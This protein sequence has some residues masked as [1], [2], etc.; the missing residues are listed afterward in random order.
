MSLESYLA[1]SG[2]PMDDVGVQFAFELFVRVELPA[3]VELV[4]QVAEHLLGGGV[5]QAVALA[6]HGLADAEAFELAPPLLVLVLPS[7]VRVQ[8]RL[9]AGGQ[10]LREHGEQALLPPEV[11]TAAHVPGDDLLAGHVV[12]GSEVRLGAG[13]LEF[14][15][16]GAELGERTGR[17]E[18]A[19][20]Q[21]MHVIARLAPV[22]VVPPPR[23]PGADG[24]S[25]SH[26][27]HDPGQALDRHLPSE[28][29]DQAHAYLS[30]AASVRRASPDLADQWL[31]IGPRHTLRMR[32]LIEVRGSGQSRYPQE[33]VE[34]VS[35]PCEQSDDGASLAPRDLDASRV[36]EFFQVRDL[37]LQIGD[38]FGEL[39]LARRFGLRFGFQASGPALGSRPERLRTSGPVLAA[40]VFQGCDARDPVHG[41][42]LRLGQTVLDVVAR[43]RDLRLPH[44]YRI[45][46]NAFIPVLIFRMNHIHRW[47]MKTRSLGHRYP[48]YPYLAYVWQIHPGK[49]YLGGMRT[50]VMTTR[51]AIYKRDVSG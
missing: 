18:V 51:P 29:V 28:L 24:A 8:D 30:V 48:F 2:V 32:Q 38:L 9:R 7:H 39:L 3:S 12:H 46:R 23:V 20:E 21:V 19:F 6:T 26:A 25:P 11:R 50:A 15:D 22:R 35:P 17:V 31:E 27:P 45:V 41:H 1:P 42:D 16:V 10:A 13:D 34:P 4:L 40:P 36:P 44:V 49:A 33:V 43:R 37:R 14:G 5:V 47:I